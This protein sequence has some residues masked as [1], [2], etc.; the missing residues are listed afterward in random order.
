MKKTSM[1][2]E[3]RKE[4]KRIQRQKKR[5]LEKQKTEEGK[6]SKKR[7]I[8]G[9]ILIVLHLILSI[10]F[11]GTMFWLNIFSISHYII[12]GSV[13]LVLWL[14]GLFSQIKRKKYGVTGKM[15][16]IFIMLVIALFTSYI[17]KMSG[18]FDVMTGK[19]VKIDT[20]VVAVM[21]DDPAE[22]IY[23]AYDYKFGLQ[24]KI[25]GEDVDDTVDHINEMLE[26]KIKTKDYQDIG[27]Q[28][29]GLHD[30]EVQA[31]IF[32]EGY[33]DVLEEQ[34][35]GFS[36]K[37]KIIYRY[38]IK[39]KMDGMTNDRQ[40]K[41]K[42]FSVNLSG[43]DVYGDI[44]TNSRSD[45]NIIATVNP[46]T[47][48]ILLITT[49]RDYYVEIPGISKGEKDKLTHAGLYG[50]DASIRTLSEL[51]DMEIPF[52][53]RVNFT[54]LIEIVDELGGV[55]VYSDMSFK[56]GWESGKKINVIQGMNHFNGE[57]ALA[58]SRERKHIPGGDNQRGQH[59][60]AVITAMIKKIVSP[61]ML[62]RANGIIDS[63]SG[64]VE[65]N[66]SRE[67]LQSLIKTQI[68]KGGAWNITSV[69]AEGEGMKGICY[70]APKQE[71]YI[72]KPDYESVE[73]IKDL[74][75][76]VES[77]EILEDSEIAE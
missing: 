3:Q 28:V 55:D 1:N 13:L 38:N 22:D 29:K 66:M 18:A 15:Y 14:I 53:A 33:K 37:I 68:R 42:P 16:I 63:V 71:L 20:M 6:E 58:F 51:Y 65:T 73:M 67:Q 26:M 34:V 45:V 75:N 77:G 17:V 7:N 5:Y 23:D 70:S 72:T 27:K 36:E 56:T 59:Q 64:N 11:F 54:S 61:S 24:H 76:K 12:I 60:Q 32:N 4:Y 35:K 9:N 39:T 74:V 49:P 48:Q 19:N 31:I 2:S 25:K 46:K 47:H 41:T 43:I 62:L 69:S 50:V 57:Q 8:F 52:F 40:V 21:K 10:I 30:G 44:S